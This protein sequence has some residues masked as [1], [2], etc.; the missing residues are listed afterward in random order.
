MRSAAPLDYAGLAELFG[1]S[2]KCVRSRMR[3]WQ[4][5]DFPAPL[6]WRRRPLVWNREAVER[7]K[8]AQEIGARATRPAIAA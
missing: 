1:M 4:A 5:R 6:P 2:E 3:E 8:H 7:W